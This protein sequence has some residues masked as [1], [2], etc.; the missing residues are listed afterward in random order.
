[1]H[2]KHLVVSLSTI[3]IVFLVVVFV[4]V[5]KT[6]SSLPTSV[7]TTTLI[8]PVPV[9]SSKLPEALQKIQNKARQANTND[10]QLVG[11]PIATSPNSINQPTSATIEATLSPSRAPTARPVQ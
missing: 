10:L 6:K 11:A 2:I 4:V 5:L 7:K 9:E 1:M 8:T 3:V